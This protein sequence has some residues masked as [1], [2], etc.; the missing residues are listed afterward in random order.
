[1]IICLA[2]QNDVVLVLPMIIDDLNFYTLSQRFFMFS[3]H[4]KK[5]CMRKKNNAVVL[6]LNCQQSLI[7]C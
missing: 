3:F 7:Q 4:P 6:P 2:A 1:M 5:K